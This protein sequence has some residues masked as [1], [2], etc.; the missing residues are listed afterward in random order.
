MRHAAARPPGQA[1]PDWVPTAPAVS[2]YPAVSPATRGIITTTNITSITNIVPVTN[3]V[4]LTISHPLSASHRHHRRDRNQRCLADQ[5]AA[6]HELHRSPV[7]PRDDKCG[8]VTNSILVTNIARVPN[9]APSTAKP[10]LP[11]SCLH[12]RRHLTNIA[13]LTNRTVVTNTLVQTLVVP[14]QPRLG[15][16]V[17]RSPIA[18][19]RRMWS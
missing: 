15:H 9:V 14:S 4:A 3:I 11:I 12:Q 8:L 6:V 10:L 16:H 7:P 17:A 19:W 18:P 13:V 5:R 2:R 1:R